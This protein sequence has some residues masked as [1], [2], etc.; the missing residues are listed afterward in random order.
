[1]H[2][3]KLG[4]TSNTLCKRSITHMIVSRV[5]KHVNSGSPGEHVASCRYWRR[6]LDN[7]EKTV[8]A[9]KAKCFSKIPYQKATRSGKT[10]KRVDG[11]SV[12]TA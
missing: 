1:M 2:Q 10:P 8:R 12:A 3:L 7:I 6:V 5:S 4:Q 9:S 11:C